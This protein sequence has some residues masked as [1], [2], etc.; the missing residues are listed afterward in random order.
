MLDTGPSAA[1]VGLFTYVAVVRRAPIVFTL[2]GGSMVWESIAVPN[3]AGREHLIAVGA[4]IVLALFH[5]GGHRRPSVTALLP[6]FKADLPVRAEN[7][8]PISAVKLAGSLSNPRTI[9]RNSH[10]PEA[11]LVNSATVAA[12][13]PATSVKSSD[14]SSLYPSTTRALACDRS[15]KRARSAVL[16]DRHP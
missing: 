8:L 6:Q 14:S 12:V 16:V 11:S 15:P 7:A 3:L 9:A 2:T 1:V 5:G 4:A 13:D 10:A